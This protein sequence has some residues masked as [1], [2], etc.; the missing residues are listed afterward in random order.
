MD[1]R[2][3]IPKSLRPIILRSLHYGH[4]GRD[5][6]LPTVANMWWPRLHREVVVIA[7]TCQQRK[8]AGE[9]IKPLLTKTRSYQVPLT[10]QLPIR[11]EINQEIATNFVDPFRNA[12]GAT[13]SYCVLKRAREV[14][15][16][17]FI[18]ICFRPTCIVVC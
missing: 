12:I 9:N 14:D 13:S 15:C 3:V 4:P 17:L 18:F 1:E 6:M 11:N 8:T 10:N 16:Y 2:L 7:L 5:S